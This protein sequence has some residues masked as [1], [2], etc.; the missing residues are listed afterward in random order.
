MTHWIKILVT[1]LAFAAGSIN[2]QE[3]GQISGSG[4]VRGFPAQAVL[5]SL[6]DHKLPMEAIALIDGKRV[7]LSAAL[8]IRD[9]N[10]RIVVNGQLPKVFKGMCVF[11]PGGQLEKVWILSGAQP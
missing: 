8:V 7:V 1:G 3:Q 2:A 6:N 11:G 4:L 10:N 9:T 5:C